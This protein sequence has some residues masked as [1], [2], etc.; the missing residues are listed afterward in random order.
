ML[1]IGKKLKAGTVL[2]CEIFAVMSHDQITTVVRKVCKNVVTA[3]MA[4]WS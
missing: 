3:E 2:E 1:R 4:D